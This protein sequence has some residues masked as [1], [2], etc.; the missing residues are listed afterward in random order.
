MKLWQG[1]FNTK[2]IDEFTSDK[3]E[4]DSFVANGSRSQNHK[5][6]GFLVRTR[7]N[8]HKCR[9]TCTNEDSFFTWQFCDFANDFL[10]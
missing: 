7:E 9:S 2:A 8:E 4:W 1:L 10:R 3:E 5:K 6:N